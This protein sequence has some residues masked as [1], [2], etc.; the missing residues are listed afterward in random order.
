LGWG[1]F[2]YGFYFFFCCV[3]CFV[4]FFFVFFFFFC[5]CFFL[6]FFFVFFLFFFFFSPPPPPP[7]PPTPPPHPP[8]HPPHTPPPPPPTPPTTPTPPHTPP[9]T[10]RARSPRHRE[11]KSALSKGLVNGRGQLPRDCCN[12]AEHE[13]GRDRSLRLRASYARESPGNAQDSL[14][15][16]VF[17]DLPS[18]V[19]A[20][21]RTLRTPEV[22]SVRRSSDGSRRCREIVRIP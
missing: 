2:V 15:R 22:D 10:P 12:H 13:L 1:F 3:V 6:L 14:R 11:V 7:P 16:V 18:V 8:P 21:R 20:C 4:F 9:P 19:A 17:F 5:V